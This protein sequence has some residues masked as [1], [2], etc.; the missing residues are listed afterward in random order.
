M[1]STFHEKPKDTQK[2]H[3]VVGLS[4]LGGFEGA[5]TEAK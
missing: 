2:G 4:D 1:W 5:L 3:K